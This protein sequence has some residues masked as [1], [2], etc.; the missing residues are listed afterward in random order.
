[1]AGFL[2][3]T[4]FS[5]AFYLGL[6]VVLYRDGRKRHFSRR[7]VYKVHAASVAELGLLPAVYAGPSP[8]R[9]NA[10]TVLVRFAEDTGRGRLKSRAIQGKPAKVITLPTL[11]HDSEDAQCG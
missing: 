11:A 9:R 3:L 7:S 2:I 8:S 1:M 10:A 6:L 5:L 4:S